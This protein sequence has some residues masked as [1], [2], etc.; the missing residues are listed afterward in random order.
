M[1]RLLRAEVLF[2]EEEAA[3]I[4]EWILCDDHLPKVV[5]PDIGFDGSAGKGFAGDGDDLPF[6]VSSGIAGGGNNKGHLGALAPEGAGEFMR[7]EQGIVPVLG[8]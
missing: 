4:A 6:G 1:L 2:Y 3:D 7:E 8:R 5:L